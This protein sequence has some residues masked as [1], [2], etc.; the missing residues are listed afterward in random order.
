MN[1]ASSKLQATLSLIR[2]GQFSKAVDIANDILKVD[3]NHFDALHMKA[4][5]LYY[6]KNLRGALVAIQRAVSIRKDFAEAYN[7]YGIILKALGRFDEAIVQLKAA[8]RLRPNYKEALYNIANCYQETSLLDQAVRFYD[9]ALR[10]DP[11]L[12]SALNNKGLISGKLNDHTA[13]IDCFTQAIR[14]EPRLAEAY[15]NR[16]NALSALKQYD[17]AVADYSAAI[18]LKSLFPTAL[19]NRANA[20][21]ALGRF[22]DALT[23][24]NRS[25]VQ[26]S[27]F[28]EAY[29]SRAVLLSETGQHAAALTDLNRA[30]EINPRYAE[31]YTNRGNV[32]KELQRFDDA[33]RDYD[34]AIRLRPDH[35]ETHCNRGNALMEMEHPDKALASYDAAIGFKP[36]SAEAHGGRGVAL[37]DL[38]RYDEALE[39]LNRALVL[40]PDYTEIHYKLGNVYKQ[41]RNYDK[42]LASYDE[43]LK[44][45]PEYAD[46]HFN[47]GLLLLSIGE[48]ANGFELYKTRWHIKKYESDA[49]VTAIPRWDGNTKIRNLLIWAEQGIGDEIFFS[50][51]LSLL[52]DSDMRITVA[53]D[54]R[55]HAIYQRSFPG[56]QL[57]DRKLQ[58]QQ[59]DSGFDAQLPIGDLGHVL[60]LDANKIEKRRYPYLLP[61]PARRA[62]ILRKNDFLM[63]KPVCGISWSSANKEFGAERSAKLTDFAPLLTNPNV[64][65]VNLQYGDVDAQIRDVKQQLNAYIYQA[66]E[67]DIFNDIDGLLALIDTCS[68]VLTTDNVTAHLA[69]AI[70]KAATVLVPH[71]KGRIWYW[72]GQ[73]HSVWYPSVR[74]VDQDHPED[75]RLPIIKAIG[76]MED[77]TRWNA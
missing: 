48:Y 66:D 63:K 77:D 49:L 60:G 62:E 17:A 43:A 39:S 19:C 64:S 8:L 36:G 69:G 47:K 58:K 30:L 13:A 22:D 35:A 52:P 73:P 14:R 55:L 53:A 57:L 26:N 45:K 2:S 5:A 23:D 46:V 10:L 71:G 54:M 28:A 50:S 59:I 75:W 68:F 72:H 3:P 6:D 4:L 21:K 9:A 11:G 7:S 74:I 70:G 29:L 1:G 41:L 15:Y 20:Y 40:K 16:G 67:L 27:H 37:A 51:L 65:V 61:D 44:L 42:A 76:I 32:Y 34:E 12:V 31:A 33:L 24:Y 38:K 18:N 56:V 25:L